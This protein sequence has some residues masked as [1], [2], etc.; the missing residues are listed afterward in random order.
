MID[1]QQREK[2]TDTVW[3]AILDVSIHSTVLSISHIYGLH[4]VAHA[5]GFVRVEPVEMPGDDWHRYGES[6]YA[7]DRAR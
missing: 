5:T 6:Q 4:V 3:S 2:L 7:S 1:G